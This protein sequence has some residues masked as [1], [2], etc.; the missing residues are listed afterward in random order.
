[1]NVSFQWVTSEPRG[2]LFK[3]PLV[4]SRVGL[5]KPTHL[6][7]MHI[8]IFLL[9]ISFLTMPIY[10]LFF[11][12]KVSYFAESE[13]PVTKK[14]PVIP[15]NEQLFYYIKIA[16]IVIHPFHRDTYSFKNI[17]GKEIICI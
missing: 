6:C 7:Q 13:S 15:Q 12:W 3:S 8:V 9:A 14:N 4:V 5:S 11:S 2:S 10:P 1:M 16:G 17:L